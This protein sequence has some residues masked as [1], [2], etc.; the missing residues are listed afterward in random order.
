MVKQFM[1]ESRVR[2]R[3]LQAVVGLHL[4]VKELM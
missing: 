3:E 4:Q 2:Y 1:K